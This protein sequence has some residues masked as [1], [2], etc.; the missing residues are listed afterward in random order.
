MV[1]KVLQPLEHTLN[2]SAHVHHVCSNSIENSK[3]KMGGQTMT[4]QVH[5]DISAL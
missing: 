2:D 4:C 3:R 1:K 5:R